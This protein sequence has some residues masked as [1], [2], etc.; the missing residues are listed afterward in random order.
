MGHTELLDIFCKSARTKI[1]NF[2]AARDILNSNSKKNERD[3]L[4]LFYLLRRK[5][6]TFATVQ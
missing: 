6:H 3:K 5:F 2:S 1:T 4:K